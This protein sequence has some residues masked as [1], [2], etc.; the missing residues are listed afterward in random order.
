MLMSF[1]ISISVVSGFIGGVI[2][3][4]AKSYADYFWSSDFFI[5]QQV[6]QNINSD[7]EA[8]VQEENDIIATLIDNLITTI[9]GDIFGVFVFAAPEGTGKSTLIKT[10]FDVIK[11][12]KLGMN[13]KLITNGSTVLQNQ[14][15]HECMMIPLNQR[16]PSDYMPP[17]SCIIIDQIDFTVDSLSYSLRRYIT[18]LATEQ[19]LSII[20]SITC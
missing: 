4:L 10:V 7:N 17:N 18:Y 8:I 3:Q 11:S 20:K 13:L 14:K 1:G 2:L 19:I 5:R 6:L 9:N 16:P 12:K 15:G